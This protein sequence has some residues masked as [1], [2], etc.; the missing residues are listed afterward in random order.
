MGIKKA[1]RKW[2]KQHPNFMTPRIVE[3]LRK[4][5]KII[6]VSEGRFLQDNLY[7]VSFFEQAGERDFS[8]IREGQSFNSLT[9][10]KKYAEKVKKVI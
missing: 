8:L 5:N 1:F 6:E 9:R 7:G 3:L 4:G 10:A 2:Q